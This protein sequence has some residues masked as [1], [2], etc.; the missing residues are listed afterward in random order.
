MSR[1]IA[2]RGRQ[3]LK[4]ELR[5]RQAVAKWKQWSTRTI[6]VRIITSPIWIQ[7]TASPISQPLPSYLLKPRTGT[8]IHLSATSK[9]REF[10]CICYE[11]TVNNNGIHKS[12]S[13]VTLKLSLQSNHDFTCAQKPKICLWLLSGSNWA[14]IFWTIQRYQW[15]PAPTSLGNSHSA[16]YPPRQQM[17]WKHTSDGLRIFITSVNEVQP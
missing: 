2:W 3:V 14:S 10:R 8:T 17:V 5:K 4:L 16:F 6:N 15:V 12:C 1:I 11:S 13:S 9:D 7:Y